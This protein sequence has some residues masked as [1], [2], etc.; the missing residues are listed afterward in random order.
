MKICKHCGVE[1]NSRNII[2]C[3]KH[4]HNLS[5]VGKNIKKTT[6]NLMSKTW[7][8]KGN[9]PKNKKN[10]VGK[11]FGRLVVIEETSERKNGGK[12]VYLCKCDCGN[13]VKKIGTKLTNGH[14]ISCGCR[15][16]EFLAD[17]I[18]YTGHKIHTFGRTLEVVKRTNKRRFKSV[19]WEGRCE[20]CNKTIEL[21]SQQ[22]RR[23]QY[24]CGCKNGLDLFYDSLRIYPTDAYAG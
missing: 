19:I 24:S 13:V 1:Y 12:V 8:K 9:S 23:K 18:D 16:K 14:T 5:Q 22:I 11:R 20:G 21:D 15:K 17:Y 3:S 10:L 6:L 4:C 7:F 2:Y